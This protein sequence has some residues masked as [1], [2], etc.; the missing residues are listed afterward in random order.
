MA[1][2]IFCKIATGEIPARIVR[3]T[4]DAVAFYDLQP[5]AP[6]HL[7]VIPTKHLGAVR[8]A[9]GPDLVLLGK[10]LSF[11]SEVASELGLDAQGYRLVSNTGPD[12][13]QSVFHLHFH[14][15][16]GRKMTWPPG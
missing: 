1:D 4:P 14:L 15:L 13:G 8:D 11:A 9:K 6:T 5:Q 12:G 7:L 10:L 3:R 2:C 16:G